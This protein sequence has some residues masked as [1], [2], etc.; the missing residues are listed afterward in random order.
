MQPMSILT[1]IPPATPVLK[2]AL[3]Q[4]PVLGWIARDVLFGDRDNIWY[5]L[6]I[7]L[8]GLILALST[9]GIAALVVTCVA[10]VPVIFATLIL[11]SWG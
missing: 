4:I 5:A 10:L 3:L 2:R 6:V 8:T 7:V 9:W 1:P 11:I